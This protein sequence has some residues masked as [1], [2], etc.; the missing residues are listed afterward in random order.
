MLENKCREGTNR[1]FS[2]DCNG[3]RHN[4]FKCF[5]RIQLGADKSKWEEFVN[6]YI[7]LVV[8]KRISDIILLF[9]FRR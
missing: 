3:K 5:I 4:S 6:V 2:S 8:V 7:V 1:C 9:T